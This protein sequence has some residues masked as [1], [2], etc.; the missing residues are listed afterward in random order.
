[1]DTVAA[2]LF[3]KSTKA[4]FDSYLLPIILA[5]IGTA[6]GAIVAFRLERRQKRKEKRNDE[7][8]AGVETLFTLIIQLETL[9]DINRY[10]EKYKNDNERH[11]KIKPIHFQP[12]H[13]NIPFNKLSFMLKGEGVDIFHLIVTIEKRFFSAIESIRIRNTNHFLLQKELPDATR[14][15]IKTLEDLTSQIYD[16]FEKTIASYKDTQQCLKEYLEKE[17]DRKSFDIQWFEVNKKK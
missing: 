14:K 10:L 2:D 12:T 13:P 6:T 5:L 15:T 7:F 11:I 4:I 3:L 1:M 8:M 9:L 17:F 16:N